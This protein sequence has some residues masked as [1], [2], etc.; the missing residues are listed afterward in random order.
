MRS[1]RQR[2][3][4]VALDHAEDRL[5]LPALAE[6]NMFAMFEQSLHPPTVTSLG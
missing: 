5:D 4:E 2:V 6:V 1:R 3:A